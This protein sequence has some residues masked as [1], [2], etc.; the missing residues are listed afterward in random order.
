MTALSHTGQL[1]LQSYCELRCTHFIPIYL[2]VSVTEIDFR[3]CGTK[4]FTRIEVEQVF[5]TSLRK[6]H[7]YSKHTQ[8]QSYEACKRLSDAVITF[9]RTHTLLKKI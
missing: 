6:Y 5:I 4:I 1:I 9:P 2:H 8:K 3:F 7:A